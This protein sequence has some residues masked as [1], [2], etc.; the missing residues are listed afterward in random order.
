MPACSRWG[1]GSRRRS[2]SESGFWTGPRW[3]CSSAEPRSHPAGAAGRYAA[4]QIAPDPSDLPGQAA[5]GEVLAAIG[6]AIQA[7]R[8]AGDDPTDAIRLL[9]SALHGFIDLELGGGFKQ[10]RSLDASFAR[11]VTT[12]DAALSQW[13]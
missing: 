4:L 12:L 13:S 5:A 7:Y 1:R 3:R 6:S 8:L 11:L 10:P 9:R 2:G